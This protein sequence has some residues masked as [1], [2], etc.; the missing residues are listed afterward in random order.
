MEEETAPPSNDWCKNLGFDFVAEDFEGTTVL[1]TTCL[2]C[3]MVTERK[4]T[5]CDISVP[6]PEDKRS[7]ER[8]VDPSA[9][10]Q[11]ACVTSECLRDQ[12]K[13]WC[14]QCARYNEARRQVTYETLPRLVVLQ[15]KR[16]SGGMEKL[17]AHMPTPLRL[18]CFCDTC[19]PLPA[20]KR[21][22]Q[23]SLYSVI[24]HLGQT[25]TGGHYIAYT[26]ANYA[27]Y[28]APYICCQRDTQ[29]SI[30]SNSSEKSNF[31]KNLFARSKNNGTSAADKGQPVK[32]RM[33][34]LVAPV[35]GSS[36]DASLCSS[37]ECCGIRLG[38]SPGLWSAEELASC[39]DQSVW[40]MCDD[41]TVKPISNEEFDELLSSKPK[42]R[43]ASTPYLLFYVRTDNE[44]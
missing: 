13:Y 20:S 33:P 35:A 38:Q 16:F 7:D 43:S 25:L 9:V 24:M 15:L 1:R 17:T 14:D 18:A 19:C 36:S 39:P 40:L 22:H 41:E 2:E 30:V 32:R 27:D 23:Y 3:E 31:M 8:T 21:P 29:N 10:Y 5:M 11:H 6:I 26:R 42:I 12:N 34:G 4:Q 37:L 44:Q 28:S